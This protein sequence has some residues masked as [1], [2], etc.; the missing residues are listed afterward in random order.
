MFTSC[1]LCI[2][3]EFVFFLF[4]MC[5]HLKRDIV[6]K[7]KRRLEFDIN[8][9]PVCSSSM[10]MIVGIC[11]RVCVWK[12]KQARDKR[13]RYVRGLRSVSFC[14]LHLLF[15]FCFFQ[16]LLLLFSKIIHPFILLWD[17]CLFL[18][19]LLCF[20]DLRLLFYLVVW[21]FSPKEKTEINGYWE[22]IRTANALEFF[23]ISTCPF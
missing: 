15:W 20:V 21:F 6:L 12:G 23:L 13:Y 11:A 14:Y 3:W 22:D 10:R 19:L 5:W 8:H 7:Q 1:Y 16:K 9:A 2:V 18:P 17:C 4:L